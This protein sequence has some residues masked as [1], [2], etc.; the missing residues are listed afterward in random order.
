MTPTEWFAGQGWCPGCR[1]AGATGA[2][3]NCDLWRAYD[4]AVKHLE[5]C[6]GA[7]NVT[8]VPPPHCRT[9]GVNT[10]VTSRGV[11][12]QTCGHPLNAR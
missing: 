7:A 4:G 6:P 1:G 12:C 8:L 9:H 3:D 10:F 2:M 11:F 5:T